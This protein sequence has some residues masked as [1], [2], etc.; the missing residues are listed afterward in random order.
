[1]ATETSV[2][3]DGEL[4]AL[5]NRAFDGWGSEQYFEWKYSAYP[6]YE[7][8]TDN[9]V[10]R[11][12]RG[13]LVAARRI[14]RRRLRTPRGSATAHVHGGTVVDEDYRGRGH[15]S[16]LLERSMA[17]SREHADYVFTFNRAGKITTD[18]HRKNGWRH[19]TLPVYSKVVSPSNVLAHY[20]LDGDIART[21]AGYASHLDRRVTR[22]EL[23]TRA[24]AAGAS[25][26]YGD[27]GGD[28]AE[29]PDPPRSAPEATYDVRAVDGRSLP[30]A[31]IE[32]LSESL[33][34]GIDAPYRFE[35]SPATVRHAGRYPEA[36]V[37]AARDGG[38]NLRGFLVAGY[39]RK[40][41][42]TECRIV[43]QT[44]AEPAATRRLF[45]RVEADARRSGADVLVACSGRRPAPG[46]ARLGTELVMWPPAFGSEPLSTAGDAWRITTYD[47]L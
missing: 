40:G 14:F 41:G 24:L 10:V 15:Y 25:A 4:F 47:V 44:W 13:D 38:E 35:R 11:N 17:H 33:R 6:D 18:H 46:W 23:V 45:E 12:D 16:E 28:G 42:L 22:S 2:P 36:T 27:R 8:T 26:V 3:D 34:D 32:E 1:M 20:V 21:I 43:E 9:F 39:L 37:Y 5:L 29:D 7:P 30:E 31:L 19:L